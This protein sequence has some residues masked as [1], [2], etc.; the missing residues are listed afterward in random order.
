MGIYLLQLMI[1]TMMSIL[2]LGFPHQINSLAEETMVD[3][4]FREGNMSDI[5]HRIQRSLT[6]VRSSRPIVRLLVYDKV[7]GYLNWILDWFKQGALKRCPTKC[8]LSSDVKDVSI[9]LA[10][11]LLLS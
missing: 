3:L 7:Q 4:S 1:L 2:I 5:N 10:L 9:I 6:T 11:N 8:Y